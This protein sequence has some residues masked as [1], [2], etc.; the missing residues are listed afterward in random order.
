MITPI[1]PTKTTCLPAPN[2]TFPTTPPWWV[3]PGTTP[4]WRSEPRPKPTLPTMPTTPPSVQIPPA[5]A[6]QQAWQ[7]ETFPRNCWD[8]R[9]HGA[10][11]SRFPTRDGQLLI[12]LPSPDSPIQ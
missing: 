7:G 2:P 10:P 9:L 5:D 6:P 12:T 11:V 3:E 8:P 4:P 1:A